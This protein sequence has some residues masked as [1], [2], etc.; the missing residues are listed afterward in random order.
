MDRFSQGQRLGRPFVL[1]EMGCLLNTP[2][3]KDLRTGLEF[4]IYTRTLLY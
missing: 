3:Y 1:D 2:V 4:L